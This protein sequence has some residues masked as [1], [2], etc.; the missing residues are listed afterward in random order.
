VAR[1]AKTRTGF[2]L[3]PMTA[4]TVARGTVA[5]ADG[6]W[7]SGIARGLTPVDLGLKVVVDQLHGG[8]F[9]QP[10][11]IEVEYDAAHAAEAAAVV[12]RL[13]AALGPYLHPKERNKIS[14]LL[15]P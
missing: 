9:A 15:A 10:T 1:I 14:Y 8:P 2:D 13:R 6:R 11:V 12:E 4:E 7:V 3:L 5:G